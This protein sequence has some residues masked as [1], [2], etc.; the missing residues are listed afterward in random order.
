MAI[1]GKALP[2]PKQNVFGRFVDD[3][4]A[5]TDDTGISVFLGKIA[6]VLSAR[7]RYVL[8]LYSGLLPWIFFSN[9]R[10]IGVP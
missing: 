5:G 4:T 7:V 2:D 9:A 6:R 10:P 8:F 3:F 1:S